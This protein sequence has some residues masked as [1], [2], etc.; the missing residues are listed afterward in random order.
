[1]EYGQCHR[2]DTTL[3]RQGYAGQRWKVIWCYHLDHMTRSYRKR[4]S[5]RWIPRRQGYA[6]AVNPL[7]C[8]RNGTQSNNDFGSVGASI[9]CSSHGVTHGLDRCVSKYRIRLIISGKKR[10]SW[11]M[12]Y[13][14]L[15]I[16]K[17]TSFKQNI[18]VK[19]INILL[20][21]NW[22]DKFY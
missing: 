4:N 6:G 2:D 18:L 21:Y 1:M 9:P 16:K 11:W 7:W 10:V 19:W 3:R 22:G 13:S 14:Q 5:Y 12:N 17:W 8:K 20:K 15:I